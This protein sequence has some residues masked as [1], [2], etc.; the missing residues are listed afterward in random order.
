MKQLAVEFFRR[1]IIVNSITKEDRNGRFSFKIGLSKLDE[2]SS[3][4]NELEKQ[5]LDNYAIEFA[6]WVYEYNKTGFTTDELL[7]IFKK[8]KGL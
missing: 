6:E 2:L 1:E 3:K 4:A 5:Q 8:E 7:I